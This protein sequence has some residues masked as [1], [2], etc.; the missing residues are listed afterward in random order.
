MQVLRCLKLGAIGGGVFVFCVA[1]V[2]AIFLRTSQYREFGF[3]VSS[4]LKLLPFDLLFSLAYAS[5]GAIVGGAIGAAV[6][7]V[8][9]R[10]HKNDA[11]DDVL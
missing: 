1:L 2:F 5:V 10:L 7:A 4:L 3:S 9:G 6:A 11:N 8:F